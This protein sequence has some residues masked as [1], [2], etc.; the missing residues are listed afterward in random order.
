MDA[1]SARIETEAEAQPGEAS[2]MLARGR[3]L[4]ANPAT[5][6]QGMKLI[7]EAAHAG[8]GEA[9]H[10]V[11]LMAALD[12]T[13]DERWTYALVYLGRAAKAGHLPSQKTLAFLAGDDTVADAIA[14]GQVL[15]DSEWHRLHDTIDA[16]AWLAT[17][18]KRT[19]LAAPRIAVAEGLISPRMCD[20]IVAR[21][22]PRLERAQVYDPRDGKGRTAQA[23]TNSEM[24]FDFDSLDLVLMFTAQRIAALTGFALRGMEP[25]SVLHYLPG[26]EFR[27]HYDFL[28]PAIASYAAEIARTGQRVA[29]LLIYLSDDFEG[30]ETAFPECQFRFKGRKGDALFFYNVTPDGK[31]DRSSLHAGLAPS[32][33]EKWL[34]SQ[35]IRNKLFPV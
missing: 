21:A 19:V 20:W 12:S 26:Q 33:G 9:S 11:S 13:M 29:T 34:F 25:A 32:R 14:R 16:A 8:S 31:P 2:D 5:T 15:Q 10:L 3:R 6:D 30:G 22:A 7:V 27:A 18:A 1:E 24:R 4:M 17:P 23:R 28:D 35:W